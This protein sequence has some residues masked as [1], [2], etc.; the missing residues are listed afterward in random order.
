[1][2]A[3]SSWTVNSICSPM[4]CRSAVES[5]DCLPLLVRL[6]VALEL[7]LLLVLMLRA[8]GK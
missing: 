4:Q 1:M 8:I 7:V 3:S 2:L 6:R 5:I